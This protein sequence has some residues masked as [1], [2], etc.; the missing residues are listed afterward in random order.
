MNQH[1]SETFDKLYKSHIK[2]LELQGKSDATIDLYSRAVRRIA[3]YF[4]RS[5]HNLTQDELKSYFSSLIKTYSWS[6]IRVDRCGLQFFWEYVLN[7]DWDWVKIVKPPVF[8]QLPDVLNVKETEL[9]LNS[10]KR[11]RYKVFFFT[12]YSMGL[13]LGEALQ[14]E[15][16]D[17]DNQRM[18]VHIRNAKGNKDRFVPLPLAT[19]KA[20]RGFWKT[21]KNPQLLFPNQIGSAETIQKATTPMDRGGVQEALQMAIRDCGIKKRI[22]VHSLRHTFATHL[23]EAGVHLRLIQDILGHA[24]PQT[25]ALYTKL[26]EPS[27]QNRAKAINDLMAKINIAFE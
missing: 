12:L 2:H 20:L 5:P 10:L 8:K 14:L 9:L 23:F 26:T 13:R 4:N 18:L 11:L 7:K 6:T 22:H 17:I 25:T 1:E 27:I 16:S 15:V 21:H 3:L 24:S 19:L